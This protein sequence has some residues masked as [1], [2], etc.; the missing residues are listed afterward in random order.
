MNRTLASAIILAGAAMAAPATAGEVLWDQTSGAWSAYAYLADNGV[1]SC[2]IETGLYEGDRSVAGLSVTALQNGDLYLG[3][4]DEQWTLSQSDAG[5]V[6]VNIGNRFSEA[7]RAEAL[8]RD[9]IAIYVPYDDRERFWTAFAKSW[10]MEI[11]FPNW[12][13]MELSLRGTYVATNLFIDCLTAY[14]NVMS[15]HSNNATPF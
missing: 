5:S 8:E 7:Y 3:I 12:Q 14:E 15:R 6:I 10:R 9:S 4:W 11:D 13:D 2:N 1:F